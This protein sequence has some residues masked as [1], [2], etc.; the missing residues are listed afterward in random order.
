SPFTT[1]LLPP[2]STLFPYTTLFRSG[3]HLARELPRPVRARRLLPRHGHDGDLLH[4]RW[5]ALA[6]DRAHARGAGRHGHQGCR[7][8]QDA[9]DLALRGGA[10]RRRR[11]VAL[12][13]PA[14][15]RPGGAG[16]AI[17]RG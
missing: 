15:A 2:T 6:L 16:P 4:C 8:L 17:A 11:A 12:H 7:R 5:D 3:L 9:A 1:P 13:V 10:G 14:L